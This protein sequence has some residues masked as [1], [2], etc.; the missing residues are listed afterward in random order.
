MQIRSVDEADL[1]ILA[2]LWKE[3][4]SLLQQSQRAYPKRSQADWLTYAKQCVSANAC[5]F[6]V[7]EKDSHLVGYIIGWIEELPIFGIETQGIVSEFVTD[8]HQSHVSLGRQLVQC[9]VDWFIEQGISTFLV[10]IPR[11]SLVEQA[12]WEA[13]GVKRTMDVVWLSR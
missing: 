3:K 9:V 4:S 13:I 1:L 7:A 8:L 11:N 2:Q 12:F 6:F 5:G 10:C